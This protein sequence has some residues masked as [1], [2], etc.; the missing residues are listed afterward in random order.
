MYATNFLATGLLC[1][2]TRIGFAYSARVER[3]DRVLE[4]N[5]EGAEKELGRGGGA[6]NVKAMVRHS[7]LNSCQQDETG[8]HTIGFP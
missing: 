1:F 6:C 5:R 2:L 3:M 4:P 7:K 8:N